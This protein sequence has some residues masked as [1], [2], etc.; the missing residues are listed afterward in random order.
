MIKSE[1]VETLNVKYIVGESGG[2]AGD[3]KFEASADYMSG[4]GLA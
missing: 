1:C 3:H 4:P 2:E